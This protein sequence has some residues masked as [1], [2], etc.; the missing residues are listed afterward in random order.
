MAAR[1]AQ[2]KALL[3]KLQVD[4]APIIE[5]LKKAKE[6]VERQSVA[7]AQIAALAPMASSSPA[8]APVPLAVPSVE[9][10]K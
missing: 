3:A 1:H 7:A 5:G 9:A 4:A 8:I 2:T 6:N 10:P